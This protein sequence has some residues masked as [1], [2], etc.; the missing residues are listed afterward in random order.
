M[1]GIKRPATIFLFLVW[2]TCNGWTQVFSPKVLLRNQV[3]TTDL[4]TL[5][6]GIYQRAR[7][8]TPRQKAEAIWRFFLTDGRFVPPGFWYHIA[9]WAYEEPQGEVLDPLKLLNSYGFG[10]CYQLAPLLEAV[11][12]AGGFEDARTWFLTGHTVA[13]V[14]YEG[15]YHHFDADMLG[16]STVGIG[17]PQTL[18]VASVSQIA[19]DDTILLSKL[20]SPTRADESK[21]V[22]PWYPADLAAAAIPDLAHLFTTTQDNWLY[23]FTRYPQGHRMD[24]MLRPGE[25]LVR[26]YRP[27]RSGYFYLPFKKLGNHWSEFPVEVSSFG[28]RTED[29]PK[30]QKD[31]RSWATGKIQYT[32]VLSDPRSFCFGKNPLLS[33][34]LRIP[35]SRRSQDDLCR[36]TESRPAFAVFEIRS[37]YVL[38]DLQITLGASLQNS[39]QSLEAAISTDGGRTWE[40][41]NEIKGPFLGSWQ[42]KPKVRVSG[43][44][45]SLTAISGQYQCLIRLSLLGTGPAEGIR[46]RNIQITSGFQLNPR[47]LPELMPGPNDLSYAP[48]GS[49]QRDSVSMPQDQ[50]LQ[51][52]SRATS[53]Q[54]I[55]EQGQSIFWPERSKTAEIIFEL[56]AANDADLSGFDVGG[57]FLDLRE[58]LA[59]DKFTAE[60]RRTQIGR[61]PA[62]EEDPQ[63][64]ISWAT[65][66]DGTYHLLWLYQPNPAWK[67]GLSVRQVLHW[68]E[69]DRQI[70]SLPPGIKKVYV[71][72]QMKGMGMDSP[73][74]A[75]LYPVPKKQARLEI[76][77]EWY[78][79]GE[80][81]GYSQEI[82]NP[83]MKTNYVVNTGKAKQIIN[84]AITLY[85]PPEE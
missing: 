32:P 70:R 30:S 29:G 79:D 5:A 6:D 61:K 52:A 55:V 7:A 22:Y 41:M 24:F 67:D 18:P 39:G 73:R 51:M 54:S 36:E 65:S 26:Y 76:T 19:G 13:E 50:V 28:I 37:P 2:M 27:E 72:Y 45:G 25:R 68:P 11:Y 63:A 69:V 83:F 15:A 58:G 8:V 31:S 81:K 56:A 14:F 75:A 74:L 42:A 77:H 49:L 84:H 38:M 9:G 71:R 85:C 43:P 20:L 48:G 80:K 62:S 4:M 35:D 40:T 12:K 66:V 64:S 46:L 53:V 34:N 3:D 57:R 17:D 78:A 59:P 33:S 23:G 10:L 21:V 82:P 16:F 44:H 60:V 47:T 1:N